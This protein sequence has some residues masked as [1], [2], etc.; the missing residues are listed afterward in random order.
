MSPANKKKYEAV[1][2]L[3]SNWKSVSAFLVSSIMFIGSNAEGYIT[4]IVEPIIEAKQ[5]ES[6][7]RYDSLLNQRDSIQRVYMAK[8]F[9]RIEAVQT[10]KKFSKGMQGALQRKQLEEQLT[11]DYLTL[12]D[13]E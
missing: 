9:A 5:I 12:M 13:G 2:A 8:S 7:L 10:D 4:G 6:T 11:N 1:I 3:V